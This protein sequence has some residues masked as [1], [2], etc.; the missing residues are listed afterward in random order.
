[1]EIHDASSKN[2]AA[3]IGF[4]HSNADMSEENIKQQMQRLFSSDAKYIKNIYTLDWREEKYTS[5][6]KDKNVD[7]KYFSYGYNLSLYDDKIH[8]V[9][10]ES[11]Y[12]EGGYLEGAILSAINIRDKLF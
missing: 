12:K 11:S 1:M 8:F 9:G 10:T 6:N 4:F 2:E 7:I 3:L 5:S